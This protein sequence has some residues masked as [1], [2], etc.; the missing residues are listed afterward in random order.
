MLLKFIVHF[1]ARLRLFMWTRTTPSRGSATTCLIPT[2]E[3]AAL[4]DKEKDRMS[5]RFGYFVLLSN[6]K[7]EP[8]DLLT[9]YFGRT[10]IEGVIKTS[11]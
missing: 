3:Y 1:Y 7:L 10:D 8:V 9:E 11:K 4:K 2:K 5:V 6:K